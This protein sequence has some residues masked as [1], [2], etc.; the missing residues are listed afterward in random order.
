MKRHFDFIVRK[1]LHNKVA[2]G[3]RLEIFLASL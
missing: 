3:G 1:V 2:V